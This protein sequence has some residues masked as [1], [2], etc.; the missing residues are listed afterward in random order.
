MSHGARKSTQPASKDQE[1]WKAGHAKWL[2]NSELKRRA[3][4]ACRQGRPGVQGDGPD[5]DD[6]TRAFDEHERDEDGPRRSR[7]LT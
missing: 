3:R 6:V 7:I 2:L 1:V 4:R 5:E